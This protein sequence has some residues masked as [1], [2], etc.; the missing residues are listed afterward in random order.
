[1]PIDPFGSVHV[2]VNRQTRSGQPPGGWIGSERLAV[3]DAVA[4][5]T[6]GSAYAE[7]SELAKGHLRSGML[8]DITILDRDLVATSTATLADVKVATTVAGGR[9]VFEA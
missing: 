1:V 8:A 9:V 2:A 3:A 5:W 7:R 6:S 4:A